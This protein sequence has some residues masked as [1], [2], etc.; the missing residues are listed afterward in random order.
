MGYI[1]DISKWNGNINWD[2]AAPQLDFVI[3]RVQDGSNYIDPL[4][5]SYVQAMK[6]RNI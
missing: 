1:V 2:V 4:Y 5:K 6:T 3:A